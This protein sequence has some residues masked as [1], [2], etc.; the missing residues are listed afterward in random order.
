MAFGNRR[1]LRVHHTNPSTLGWSVVQTNDTTHFQKP[2]TANFKLQH[3]V[4]LHTS[5]CLVRVCCEPLADQLLQ[6]AEEQ[7]DVSVVVDGH[8]PLSKS[9]LHCNKQ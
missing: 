8:L 3:E 5:T 9:F 1:W 7:H 4:P 2:W 6:Q